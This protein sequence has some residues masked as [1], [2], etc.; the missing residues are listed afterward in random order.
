MARTDGGRYTHHHD[1]ELVV[2]LIGMTV[3]RWWRVDQWLPTM[4]AMGPMLR[5]LS[6]D[7]DSGLRGYRLALEGPRPVVVQYWDSVDKLYAYASDRTATHRP[8]WA[9]FNQRARSAPG[10]VGVWHETF[11]VDRAESVYVGTPLAGLAKA[12]V[13]VPVTGRKD[14]ARQRLEAT[15]TEER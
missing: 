1:G 5:E 14:A 6:R 7:P 8:A 12:T 11:L 10:V 3:N 13:R 2:F 15:S 4:L 9:A